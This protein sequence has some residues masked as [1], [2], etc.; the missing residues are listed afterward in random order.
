MPN[1]NIFINFLLLSLFFVSGIA[2]KRIVYCK[3][4]ESVDP[5]CWWPANIQFKQV[6]DQMLADDL[7]AA[8]ESGRKFY[9]TARLDQV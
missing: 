7:R 5:P 3:N 6:S 1:V 2:S 8:Y 4:G 9:M